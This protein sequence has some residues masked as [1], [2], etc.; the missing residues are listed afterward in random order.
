M[1]TTFTRALCLFVLTLAFAG[2][3]AAQFTIS[4]EFRP[5]AEYRNGYY[6]L[7]DSTMTGYG[8]ILG[9]SR[10]S[11]GY[12]SEK[13]QTLISLQHAFTFGENNY[14]SDSISKNT[15]NIYEGWLRYYFTKGFAVRIGRMGL[16]YDDMRIFGLSNWSQ[17]GATHDIVNLE[18]NVPS[19]KYVGDYGFAINNAAP[20]TVPYLGDYTLKNYKYMSYLYNQMKF[21][22]EKLVVSVLGVVDA[23]QMANTT[24]T[25]PAKTV[26][27]WVTNGSDTVGSFTTKIAATTATQTHNL[28][29]YA[30]G[31]AGATAGFYWKNLSVFVNGFYQTGKYK[32]G[33]N[34]NAYF[35][36]GW[37]S[38]RVVKP[39]T[40]L[41]GYERLSGN[42][43]SDTT[44]LK[45]EV[46]GFATPFS[47]KHQF[48]G[49]MDLYT[50][51]LG[52]DALHNGLNDL[53]GRATVRFSE[54]T[55]LEATY[56]WFTLPYGY[57]PAKIVK[58]GDL[59]YQSVSKQL[60]SEIDLMFL[61]K[62]IPNLELNAAYCLYLNS[63]SKEIMDGLK[64]GTGRMG[65]YA[66]V[67]LTY[68]PNF[69]TSEKK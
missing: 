1:K 23:Y 57:L 38:Y 28:T 8:T 6:K 29:I 47:T 11:F 37:V 61:Y 64:A 26:T 68:K 65:Q 31:T 10:I 42:N 24:T 54:K 52:Q 55:S 46:R 32:D 63:N 3:A 14:A 2:N 58:K 66:Y 39:L 60:G 30:R 20:A 67:M 40:L 35:M 69:F 41:I 19:A 33:R 62:P 16:T 59:P 22:K 44:K 12:N 45:T 5:R 49:Y 17:W 36:G 51:Y 27:T 50:S 48:Y 21:L 43:A 18:W 25:T 7:G 9:R 34:M 15:I 56:R 4:G 13:L 53:Y